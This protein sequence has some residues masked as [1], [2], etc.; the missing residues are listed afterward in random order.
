MDISSRLFL[1]FFVSVS[2]A[3]AGCQDGAGLS[4]TVGPA[5]GTVTSPD[6]ASVEVPAGALDT[7]VPMTIVRSNETPGGALGPAFRFAP[8][9]QVFKKPVRVFLPYTPSPNLPSDAVETVYLSHLGSTTLSPGTVSGRGQ[10]SADT[11]GLGTFV[12]VKQ[13]STSVAAEQDFP[14]G[15]AVNTTHTYWT[16][17]GTAAQKAAGG[18]VMRAP[19]G[20]TAAEI[21]ASGQADP[22]HIALSSAYAYWTDGGSGPSAGDAGIMKAPLAGGAPVRLIKASFPIDLAINASYVFWTDA[23]LH[24]LNRANLDGSNA[25]VL[26]STGDR[27]MALALDG[28]N[29]YWLSSGPKGGRSGAV[30]E[31]PIEGGAPVTLASA[32]AEPASLAVDATRVFWVNAGDGLVQSASIGGGAMQ[33]LRHMSRPNAIAVDATSYYVGEVLPGLVVRYPKASGTGE[34]RSSNEGHP[35]QLV[36]DANN[37]Y[38]VNDGAAPFQGDVRVINK[39][40]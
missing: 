24:T 28:S 26:A 7:E 1:S 4:G 30:M 21:F 23:D 35:N 17:G 20:S 15:L 29:V 31:V 39:T 25:T 33:M 36:L 5:G 2:L 32:Q 16:S 10:I 12:A 40:P 38:W 37:V 22:K 19:L 3:A 18:V 6:G 11:T 34:V 13:S 27:P 14:K 8:D 9:A